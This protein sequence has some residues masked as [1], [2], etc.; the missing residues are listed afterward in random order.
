[1]LVQDPGGAGRNEQETGGGE[2]QEIV[3]VVGVQET[4]SVGV[5]ETEIVGL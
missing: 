4:E 2:V 5:Q 3:G 1:M